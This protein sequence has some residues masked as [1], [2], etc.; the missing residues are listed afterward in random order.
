MPRLPLPGSRESPAAWLRTLGLPESLQ[1]DCRSF[2]GPK[3]LLLQG[4]M[5]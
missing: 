2:M 3:L 5:C 4:Q 1:W